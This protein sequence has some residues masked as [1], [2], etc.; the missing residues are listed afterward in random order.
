MKYPPTSSSRK[1]PIRSKPFAPCW[2]IWSIP[3][4]WIA[5]SAEM[6]GTER[7][8]WR[9]GPPP[10]RFRRASKSPSS[11]RRRCWRTSIGGPSG[12]VSNRCRFMWR[13]CP[14]SEVKK[15][16][17]ACWKASRSGVWTS[18]S[19]PIGCCKKT[20]RFGIWGFWSS[21]KNIVS[22]FPT[23]RRSKN[24]ASTWMC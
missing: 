7:P 13:C 8:K 6:S 17:A 22:A 15:S 24:F 11:C 12:S 1:H 14:V 5:S 21:T 3:G 9:S 10:G 4:R 19:A 18:S 2:R 20:C 23:R 16:R